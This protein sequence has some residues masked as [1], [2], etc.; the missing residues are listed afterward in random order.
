MAPNFEGPAFQAAKDL[1]FKG[2][3]QKN[4]YTEEILHQKRRQAKAAYRQGGSNRFEG[5]KGVAGR[6]EKGESFGGAD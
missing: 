5:L 3:D 4:G 1:I 2:R 6:L